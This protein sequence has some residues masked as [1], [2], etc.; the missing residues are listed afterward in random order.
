MRVE[1]GKATAVHKM[2]YF[3]E[4]DV[5]T[6]GQKFVV[7]YDTGSGN[8][9]IPGH[10]CHDT[11]CKAHRQFEPKRS[12]TFKEVNCNGHKLHGG[13]SKDQLTI[14]FGTGHISGKCSQDQICVG[15]LCSE[16]TF[17]S[18]TAESSQPFAAFSFDGV[19]GL[20]RDVLAQ[21][22]EYSLMGRM[23]R[24]G[25]LAEPLFSVESDEASG[26]MW[27]VGLGIDLG[28][29]LVH[30]A[31]WSGE[32]VEVLKDLSL[33]ANIA[34][35]DAGKVLFG[36]EAKSASAQSPGNAFSVGEL[37][38]ALHRQRTADPYFERRSRQD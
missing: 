24:K 27:H 26:Q 25:L 1:A 6:P 37:L 15:N 10:D 36:H 35:T 13:H 31:V 2:A 38:A 16:G 20:G 4:I 23:V 34:V 22:A 9:L 14:T 3:G 30:V 12:S 8:L 7:V 21:G 18:S 29:S 17:V 33:P 11:A 19:L 28:S 32:K 5:G